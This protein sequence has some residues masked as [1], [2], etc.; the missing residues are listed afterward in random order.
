MARF[1]R[2]EAEILALAEAMETGLAENTATA[3]L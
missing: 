2:T 3:I 1:P